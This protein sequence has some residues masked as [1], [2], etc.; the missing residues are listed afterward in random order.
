MDCNYLLRMSLV[1]V[2]EVFLRKFK[3][4]FTDIEAYCVK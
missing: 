4:K 3:Q 2:N 1:K